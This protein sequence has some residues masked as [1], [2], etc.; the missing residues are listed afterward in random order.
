MEQFSLTDRT[1]LVTGGA[2]GIGLAAAQRFLE[3]GAKVVIGDLNRDESRKA[4]QSMGDKGFELES[5]EM[6][7]SDEDSII[8]V[9]N[10]VRKTHGS[11]DVLVNSAGTGARMDATELPLKL[12]QKVMD[13]NLTGCFLCSREAAGSMLEQGS[14][15]IVNV[16]SIMGLVGGGIYP[17]PAYQT[18]K[19]G[20]VNLT[21]TLALDWA[22][23]GIR[24]MQSLLLFSELLSLKG[25]WKN[26]E[27]NKNS[28]NEPRWVDWWKRPKLQMPFSFLP[29]M[30]HQ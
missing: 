10:I 25:F 1:A 23:L 9:F 27:W 2:S 18:S 21:R 11:I 15:S 24:V 22:K 28:L 4:V 16:A 6:D 3:A 26:L 13:V 17:N 8:N 5:L 7:V 19:G 29:A 30:P 12:W 20:V 14:G